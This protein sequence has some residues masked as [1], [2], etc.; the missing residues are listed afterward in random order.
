MG[1]DR[2][3]QLGLRAGRGRYRAKGQQDGL[4]RLGPRWSKG[5]VKRA[6]LVSG[7]VCYY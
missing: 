3:I 6:S 5:K 7:L 2:E 4:K 1:L